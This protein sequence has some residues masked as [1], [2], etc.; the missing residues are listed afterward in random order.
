MRIIKEFMLK[1]G[2]D[3]NEIKKV[4]FKSG[5][6]CIDSIN[7]SKSLIILLCNFEQ[8]DIWDIVKNYSLEIDTDDNFSDYQ[9]TIMKASLLLAWEELEE[10]EEELCLQIYNNSKS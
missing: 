6:N 10:K 1:N 7:A 3:L 2:I 4:F 8:K 5:E 9:K